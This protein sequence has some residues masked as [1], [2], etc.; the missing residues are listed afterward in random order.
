MGNVMEVKVCGMTDAG[1]IR[2]VAAAGPDYAGFILHE[3][4]PRHCHGLSS[5]IVGNL[6]RGIQPVLVTVDMPVGILSEVATD[7]GIRIL[8]LHGSETPGICAWLRS[9]GFEVWKAVGIRDRSALCRLREYED[10]VDRFVFDTPSERHGGT[11]RKFDWSLI[12]EYDGRPG[13]M[14]GGGIGPGDVEIVKGLSHPHL[15]GV[16]INSR[17]ETRPGIKDAVAVGRFIDG[18]KK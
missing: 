6:P 13:F 17:F 2:D 15:V 18:L 8:Q 11:G 7:A 14:L 4:S 9:C 1:N 16:D 10:V 12:G 3:R 5:G